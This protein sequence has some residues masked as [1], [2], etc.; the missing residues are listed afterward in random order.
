MPSQSFPMT[1]YAGRGILR[2][3]NIANAAFHLSMDSPHVEPDAPRTSHPRAEIEWHFGA[4][5]GFPVVVARCDAL[6]EA[7]KR[8]PTSPI[9]EEKKLTEILKGPTNRRMLV[10]RNDSPALLTPKQAAQRLQVSIETLRGFVNDGALAFINMGRGAKKKRMAFDP[11]DIEE[12]L[13]NRKRRLAP[14]P[15]STGRKARNSITSIS[16]SSNCSLPCGGVT[17]PTEA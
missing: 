5:D 15:P 7:A 13:R 16:G 9:V 17:Q 4:I 3:G 2:Q 14:C 6:G 10:D 1:K 8:Q 11:I 12:F